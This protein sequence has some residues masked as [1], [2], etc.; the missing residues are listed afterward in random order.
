[1][2]VATAVS[3]SGRWV[4]PR[5]ARKAVL[6]A[7]VVLSVAWLGIVATKLALAVVA[8]SAADQALAETTYRLIDSPVITITRPAA[9]GALAT[10]LVLS[11]GTRWGLLKHWWIVVKFALT[12][13]VIL[14]GNALVTRFTLQALDAVAAAGEA[15]DGPAATGAA[16]LLAALAANA[17][18]L[19]A[20]T[21]IS[22]FK[23]W[24]LTP[25][26]RRS[27]HRPPG[28]PVGWMT[29]ASNPSSRNRPPSLPSATITRRPHRRQCCT[30]LTTPNSPKRLPP[31]SGNGCALMALS[32]RLARLTVSPPGACEL[33]L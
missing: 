19:A 16:P 29:P 4:L 27:R 22:T 14:T 21:V 12:F 28:W 24:G 9:A 15:G 26:G 25:R 31:A 11:L 5:R 30:V 3:D 2:T 23:P 32:P 6:A 33:W 17:V 18:M 8:V 1:M 7:H 20:A 10:G 13:A